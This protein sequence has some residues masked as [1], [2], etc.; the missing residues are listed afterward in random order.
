MKWK[1]QINSKELRKFNMNCC[2]KKR[3]ETWKGK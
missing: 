3:N 2:G 1:A